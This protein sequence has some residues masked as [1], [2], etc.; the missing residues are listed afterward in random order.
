MND[1]ER[2]AIKLIRKRNA[3]IQCPGVMSIVIQNK[4]GRKARPERMTILRINA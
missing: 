1:H 4:K 3:K 2:I